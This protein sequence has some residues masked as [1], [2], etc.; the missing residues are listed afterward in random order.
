[1]KRTVPL[2]IAS[3]TGLVMIVAAFVPAM[4]TWE[5]EVMT[6]FNILAAFAFILGGGNL[7]MTHLQ[8]VS[9]QKAGWGYS[10]I[11]LIAFVYTLVVGML[12]VGVAP[13]DNFPNHAWSGAVLQEGG[14]LWWVFEYII[15]PIDSTFFAMLAFFVASA[16]FRAFRAK[17]TESLLLLA[18]A[19]LILLGQTY[20]GTVLTS[21]L[22]PDL[23][24]DSIVFVIMSV[25]NLAG[26]R[27]IMI[28]IALGIVSTSLKVILGI[29]RSYIGAA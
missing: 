21:W 19:F 8:A 29:D 15:N 1:M 6:W 7:L 9:D 27:A 4:E 12:K 14:A 10:A 17:N 24:L 28:G 11:T 18:T 3:L 5:E 20:A 16:A 13:A 25:F 26:T 23:R 22:P 2:L